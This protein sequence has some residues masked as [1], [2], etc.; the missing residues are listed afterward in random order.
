MYFYESST[1]SMEWT[2]QHGCFH[3]NVKC[4]VV[5]QYMCEEESGEEGEEPLYPRNGRVTDTILDN[6]NATFDRDYGMHEPYRYYQD[7]KVRER[8]KGLFLADQN[9]N[10]RDTAIHT[11]QNRNGDRYGYECPEERDYYPYWHPS[12]WTDIAVFTDD[13]SLCKFFKD[14]SQ[15]VMAKGY[16]TLPEYNHES[17]CEDNG[18]EWKTAGGDLDSAPEC[19][20]TEFSRDNHLGNSGFRP[21]L[22]YNWSVPAVPAN[23]GESCVLR[24]RYNVST[25][26]F[27]GW[28]DHGDGDGGVTAKDNGDLSPVKND[29]IDELDLQLAIDTA[30]FGRTFQDR[31]HIF[32]IRERP[33][34]VDAL[35]AGRIWNLN[36]RGRRGNIVQVYPSVE[37]DFVPNT[38]D[39]RQGDYIHFQWAGSDS[40][41]RGNDGEGTRG[42]DR[43]NI[44]QIDSR[45]DNKMTKVDDIDFLDED[46]ETINLF[47]RLGQE[48]C[49]D[50]PENQEAVDNCRKLNS[51]SAYFDG[52]LVQLKH[53]GTYHYMSTRNNNFSNRSQKGTLIVHYNYVPLLIAAAALVL[54]AGAA[55]MATAP[56]QTYVDNN[57]D[58]KL[59]K[60]L[61]FMGAIF[62]TFCGG[63]SAWRR[64]RAKPI[65][66][67]APLPKDRRFL[68][69]LSVLV[70]INLAS[71]TY[72]FLWNIEGGNNMWFP[73]A[74]AGG[75]MLNFN[76]AFVIFP[77][78][79]NIVSLFRHSPIARVLPLDD[80]VEFHKIGA[81]FALLGMCIHITGH[82]L[83]VDPD[84]EAFIS[85]IGITGH[86]LT[87]I[88]VLMAVTAWSRVRGRTWKP[89]GKFLGGYDIFFYV[90]RLYYLFFLILL[91]HGP[92]FWMWFTF[93]LC[94]FVLD[95]IISSHRARTATTLLSARM[96]KGRVLHVKMLIKDFH[97]RA[98]QYIYINAPT[99]SRHQWHPFTISSAPEDPFISLHIRVT[100]DFTAALQELL[101]GK[102][103]EDLDDDGSSMLSVGAV[104]ARLAPNLK[105]SS[106]ASA[107][108]EGSSTESSSAA[109]SS[110]SAASSSSSSAA[111]D[112]GSSTSSSSTSSSSTVTGSAKLRQFHLPE[113][114]LLRTDGPYG[115]ATEHVGDFEKVLLVGAGIGVTP[116]ASVLRSLLVRRQQAVAVGMD[117]SLIYPS[118]VQMIWMCRDH[119][120]FE[121]F[122]DL[123]NSVASDPLIRDVVK[124]TT[125]VTGEMNLDEHFKERL[126]DGTI[127]GEEDSSSSS[128]SSAPADGGSSSSSGESTSVPIPDP[129][130]EAGTKV[131]PNYSGRPNW[132]RILRE[133]VEN[134]PEQRV[135]V[136]LCGPAAL[137]HA[138]Q[139]AASVHPQIEFRS[140]RFN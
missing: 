47:A 132:R 71:A 35:G 42:T 139:D 28:G 87:L 79:R 70:I 133:T 97:Y 103:I 136:F 3:D 75:N 40:N 108:G 9:L 129:D 110:S 58:T 30:Q 117:P 100:G 57:P 8:N 10:N 86:L 17:A 54:V 19:L 68:K 124:V 111:A 96:H 15:N 61:L 120:E 101:E 92:R 44:V 84:F 55:A 21:S 23:G 24:L 107:S 125:Y 112:G 121:W 118:N 41:P 33:D 88:F 13:Y 32:S 81:Y 115:S 5:L 78:M 34:D 43:S 12:P 37:Y 137:S 131:R 22:S 128:S 134:A 2:V 83:H 113:S 93:P 18:G 1:L 38:L 89:F 114:P 20:H 135:G 109:S 50:E 106:S 94:F 39:V 51:A 76:C 11:R 122:G 25:S 95:R 27:Q 130:P 99:V 29:Y 4:N 85:F 98:G 65:D 127:G 31:S 36:V 69:F 52:G 6:V 48:N 102:G 104:G 7:C 16:C 126:Q 116:F 73:V 77:V 90:H 60:V 59:A 14:E 119:I 53:R 138:I 66:D 26:D 140:E 80:N 91:T 72:G 46:R 62:C 123:L 49:N 63:W 74:K 67:D 105:S 64:S 82:Y 45:G 56:A